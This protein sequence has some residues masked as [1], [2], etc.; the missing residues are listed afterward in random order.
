MVGVT[1]HT[2]AGSDQR[3]A[4]IRGSKNFKLGRRRGLDACYWGQ[5]RRSKV[6]ESC[7]APAERRLYE[8]F[9]HR[10]QRSKTGK[11]YSLDGRSCNCIYL[12]WSDPTLLIHNVKGSVGADVIVLDGK[13]QILMH[14]QGKG[15]AHIIR[16]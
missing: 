15:D 13:F 2:N 3:N 9:R 7:P 6:T 14:L 1:L 10:K 12:A 4:L 11:R 5:Y 8:Y 16:S